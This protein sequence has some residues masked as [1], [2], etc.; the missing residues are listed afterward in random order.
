MSV[1]NREVIAGGMA[2]GVELMTAFSYES[3]ITITH[4]QY[5]RRG[6]GRQRQHTFR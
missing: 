4:T 1:I 2:L 6:H 5:R 3:A